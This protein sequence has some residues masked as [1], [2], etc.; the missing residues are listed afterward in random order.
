MTPVLCLVPR[1]SILPFGL[2]IVSSPLCVIALMVL[3]LFVTSTS[4][5]SITSSL[6]PI[7]PFALLPFVLPLL[8][9]PL[10]ALLTLALLPLTLLP[11]MLLQLMCLLYPALL[12]FVF[13]DCQFL[14]PAPV[15]LLCA[16]MPMIVGLTLAVS[17]V[18]P[19]TGLLLRRWD[20]GIE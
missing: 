9:L 14:V 18:L 10:L 5:L 7:L 15:L 3:V 8:T 19:L 17:V 13:A 11:L 6:P 2:R 1:L 4:M 20:L 12:W 16:F